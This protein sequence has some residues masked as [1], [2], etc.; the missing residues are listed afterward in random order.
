MRKEEE[1]RGKEGEDGEKE[2]REGKSF[3]SDGDRKIAFLNQQSLGFRVSVVVWIVF[4]L[5]G[6]WVRLYQ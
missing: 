1:K 2:R 4:S 6:C 5:D 3:F